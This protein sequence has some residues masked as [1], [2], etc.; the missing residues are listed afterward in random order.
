MVNDFE[1]VD[2]RLEPC[3]LLLEFLTGHIR[4]RLCGRGGRCVASRCRVRLVGN[5]R[6]LSSRRGLLLSLLSLLLRPSWMG[7][8]LLQRWINRCAVRVSMV[9]RARCGRGQGRTCWTRIIRLLG[10][11]RRSWRAM[12]QSVGHVRRRRRG[13][14]RRIRL[15]IK[16]LGRTPVHREFIRKRGFHLC[17]SSRRRRRCRCWPCPGNGRGE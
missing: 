8:S 12:M 5:K 1:L 11:R 15:I 2:T 3:K 7:I 16:T 4:G 13:K 9:M 10:T 17:C 6:A 14:R